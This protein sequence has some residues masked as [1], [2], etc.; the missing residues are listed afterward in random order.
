VQPS[1]LVESVF[2]NWRADAKTGQI[3]LALAQP[4]G[5]IRD[6]LIDK[7]SELDSIADVMRQAL[8]AM[9]E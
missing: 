2:R 3:P 5:P 4:E 1:C 8:D 7:V 9:K 6:R